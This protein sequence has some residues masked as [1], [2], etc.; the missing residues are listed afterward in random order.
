MH[1]AKKS[2]FES[3]IAVATLVLLLVGAELKGQ[4][5]SSEGPQTVGTRDAVIGPND[6]LNI[7]VPAAQ[8]IT[9]TWRVGSTGIDSPA[10]R[11]SPGGRKNGG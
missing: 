2:A 8:N 1:M 5:K 3:F 9:K 10:S 6:A 4:E 11:K 7:F